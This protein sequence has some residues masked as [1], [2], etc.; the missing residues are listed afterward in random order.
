[1]WNRLRQLDIMIAAAST[2]FGILVAAVL[3]AQTSVLFDTP[4]RVLLFGFVFL[5]LLSII[6]LTAVGIIARKHELYMTTINTQ[7]VDISRAMHLGNTAHSL[8]ISAITPINFEGTDG[9][10]MW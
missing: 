3:R 8:G 7:L 1:M 10:R 6:S 9:E 2:A 5:A 4:T